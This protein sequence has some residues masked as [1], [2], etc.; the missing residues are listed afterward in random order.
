MALAHANKSKT[1]AA[2]RRGHLLANAPN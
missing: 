2:Y 1:E